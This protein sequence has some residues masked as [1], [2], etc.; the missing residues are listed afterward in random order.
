[1]TDTK[2]EKQFFT[3][4]RVFFLLIVIPLSLVAILIA[5]GIFKLGVTVREKAITVLD[6]K[7][8]EEIKIRAINLADEVANF[9]NERKKDLLIATII[10]ATDSAFQK[11]VQENRRNIWVKE[12]G[13]LK[14]ISIPLYSE[15]SLIDKNGN[16][17]I[18]I[19]NG[20]VVPPSKLVNV[21]N[22]VNTTYKSEVYF[23]KAKALN[24]GEVYVSPVTGWY[25]TRSE[26]E[27]G[28]RFTGVI[29]FATPIYGREGF[30]GVVQLALDYRHL[31]AF[32]DHIVPTSSTPVFE[33]DAST[34]NYA[35]MVD[36]QGFIISHP[37]DFHIRGLL[38]D[39]TPA[40]PLT[41]ENQEELTKKGMEVLN[42]TQMGYLDPNIPQVASDAMSGKAGI[43]MYKFAGHTK[44]VAYAPIKFYTADYPPP[45]GFGWIAMG[46]DVDKFNE[47]AMQTA[48]NI[49]K[50]SRAWTTTIIVIL[51]I[52]IIILFGIA[53]LL[54]RGITRSLET[55]VP[56]GAEGEGPFYDD[57]EE[58]EK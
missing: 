55:P 50:E 12:E 58:E 16:E 18:K 45:A 13:K 37:N 34:G 30:Q 28:K 1:M 9:L 25:V 56:E 11:F 40:P 44:F 43:K 21:S 4:A 35:Y 32:T 8:Q 14:Q 48:K 33:A 36:N 17:V 7:A 54:A 6:Q 42:L 5:N 10:P 38:R 53:A 49:E 27:K 39:G 2:K 22:P 23:A 19:A 15:M 3:V 26:F 41:K 47:L 51:T 24:K 29:R 31:A 57:E 20:Q 52:S 46:V